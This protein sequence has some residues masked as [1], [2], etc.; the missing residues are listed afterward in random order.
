MDWKVGDIALC[1]T[2]GSDIGGLEVVIKSPPIWDPRKKALV[3]V[4]DPGIPLPETDGP[5]I[6]WGAEQRYL[7]PAPERTDFVLH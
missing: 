2:P 5:C 7:V 1:I 3:H 6:G 4:V